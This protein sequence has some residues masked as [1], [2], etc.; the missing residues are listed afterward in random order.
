MLIVM[1][2]RYEKDGDTKKDREKR[3]DREQEER[4]RET[5]LS[6][7]QRVSE[8]KLMIIASNKMSTV[9]SGIH[10]VGY[11]SLTCVRT[12]MG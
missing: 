8:K 9:E 7:R 10:M 11:L 5:T 2:Y 1:Q 3:R 4:E 6:V 12:L